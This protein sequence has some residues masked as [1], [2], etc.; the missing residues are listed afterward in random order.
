MF[1]FFHV[2][3]CRILSDWYRN[4]LVVFVIICCGFAITLFSLSDGR[5]DEFKNTKNSFATL[6][7]ASLGIHD[8]YIFDNMKFGSIAGFVF[9][10]YIVMTSVLFFDLVI[11]RFV[12]RHIL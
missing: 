2:L 1:F 8:I 12:V 11:A 9:I 6:F 7:N 10:V 4:L 3:I 5:L